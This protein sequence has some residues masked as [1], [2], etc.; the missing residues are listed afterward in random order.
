MYVDWEYYKIF[1]YVAKYQNF[2]RA[3]RVLGNNQP[4]ITHTMNKL[5]DQL[6]CVLFIRSNRGVT[7]TE[8]GRELTAQI[9]P[10]VERSRKIQNYYSERRVENRARLAISTQRYPFCAKAFVEFLHL[11]DEPRIEVSLKETDM[12]SVIEEV[13]GQ[14][15]DLGVLF[16]TDMTESFIRRILDGRNLEFFG[17][18]RI[19]PHVFLRRGHPL[20]QCAAVTPEQLRAY[21]SVVFTQ[22]ESNLNYAEEAVVGSGADFDRVVYINDRAT[23]YNVIAHT[24]CV[25]TGSGVLPEGYGDERLVSIPLCEQ[26]GDMRLGYV[27]LR[28]IPLTEQGAQF[29]DILKKITAEIGE[30]L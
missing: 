17:L 14:Q 11:L 25:S 24:D 13:A 26:V 1:Y 2:T 16:V 22:R 30:S 7:L 3:A 18:V 6:H 8:E 27:K 12:S 20:A 10:L 21:P 9:A 15:S 23:A 19:R 4:N 28:G 29:V 5:E